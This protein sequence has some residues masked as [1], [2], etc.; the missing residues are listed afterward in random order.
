MKSWFENIDENSYLIIE[1]P[2]EEVIL[3]AKHYEAI[4]KLTNIDFTGVFNEK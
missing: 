3:L 4:S 1:F 2:P